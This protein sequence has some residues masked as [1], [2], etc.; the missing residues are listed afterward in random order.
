VP[1]HV[2]VDREWQP[3]G[4]SGPGDH[5]QESRGRGRTATLGNED[6]SRFRVLPTELTQCPDLGQQQ[7]LVRLSRAP[8]AN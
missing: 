6:I 3:R 2:W 5:F 8:A 7:T 4:L 1:Q